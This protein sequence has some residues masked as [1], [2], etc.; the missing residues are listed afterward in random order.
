MAIQGA[1]STQCPSSRGIQSSE[2]IVSTAHPRT[3]PTADQKPRSETFMED[4][5]SACS[6]LD[7]A[8]HPG[9]SAHVQ[10]AQESLGPIRP[11]DATGLSRRDHLL[12]S[13]AAAVATELAAD[14]DKLN[15]AKAE[16]EENVAIGRNMSLLSRM[17]SLLQPDSSA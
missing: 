10:S 14:A 5:L 15:L 3:R 2:P 11:A 6:T 4:G 16:D 1:G 7:T 8:C 13:Y 12:S 17:K 9:T